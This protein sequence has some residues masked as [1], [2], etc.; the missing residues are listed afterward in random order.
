MNEYNN[1]NYGVFSV[2]LSRKLITQAEHDSAVDALKEIDALL[3][4]FPS[5]TLDSLTIIG[6]DEE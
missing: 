3:G 6:N 2:L 1:Y 4:K 5:M